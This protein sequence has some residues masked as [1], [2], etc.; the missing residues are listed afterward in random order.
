[1]LSTGIVGSCRFT[2]EGFTR[3]KSVSHNGT[4]KLQPS[5]GAPR[6]GGEGWKYIIATFAPYLAVGALISAA[7][8]GVWAYK[9]YNQPEPAKPQV[10]QP[11]QK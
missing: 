6:F 9:H 1:M 2:P 4:P 5:T 3:P 8:G 10:Q 11:E 7:I